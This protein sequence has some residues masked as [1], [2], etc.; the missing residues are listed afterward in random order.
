MKLSCSNVWVTTL[1]KIIVGLSPSSI[2]LPSGRKERRNCKKP[3]I[4]SYSSF[5]VQD[6]VRIFVYVKIDVVRKSI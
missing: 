5:L 6:F 3:S 1:H 2:P 4:I